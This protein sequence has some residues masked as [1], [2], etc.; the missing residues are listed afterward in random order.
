MET[1]L[2]FTRD[3]LFT[4]DDVAGILGVRRTTGLGCM[5]RGVISARKIGVGGR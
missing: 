2:S 5:R 3:D 1:Q 4:P